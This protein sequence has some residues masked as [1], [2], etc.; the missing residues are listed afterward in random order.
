MDVL[1]SQANNG[2]KYVHHD[3]RDGGW[4]IKEYIEVIGTEN[5]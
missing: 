3:E 2:E 4:T 5:A 1:R